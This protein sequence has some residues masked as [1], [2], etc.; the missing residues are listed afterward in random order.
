MEYTNI[1]LGE[2]HNCEV[3]RIFYNYL[4]KQIY[5]W[6]NLEEANKA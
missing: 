6:L 3:L 4:D 2:V 1:M 5:V